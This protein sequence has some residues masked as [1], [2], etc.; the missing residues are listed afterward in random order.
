[1][2]KTEGTHNVAG[3]FTN[4][5]PGT[6]VEENWCNAVQNEIVTVVEEAGLTLKTAATETGNLIHDSYGKSR[7]YYGCLELLLNEYLAWIGEQTW[8]GTMNESIIGT[9]NKVFS[10]FIQAQEKEIGVP[11]RS[12][13]WKR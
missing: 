3:A 6:R 13:G 4:G 8:L 2:H 5:P 11:I 1:M 12:K 7:K 10:R 9:N